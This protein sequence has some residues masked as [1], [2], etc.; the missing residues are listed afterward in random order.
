MVGLLYLSQEMSLK[1]QTSSDYFF[2]GRS[3]ASRIYGWGVW[4]GRARVVI[5][6]KHQ[7]YQTSYTAPCN[8]V[9]SHGAQF[10]VL[11]IFADHTRKS[12]CK[13]NALTIFTHR[14]AFNAWLSSHSGRPQYMHVTYAPD[15]PRLFC[16]REKSEDP[17]IEPHAG[18][19]MAQAYGISG[20]YLWLL[21]QDCIVWPSWWL[22]Q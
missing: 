2:G 16:F 17:Q 3:V 8:G 9:I 4:I 1:C 21:Y 22:R 20:V 11:R 10:G 12:K 6:D 5:T 19:K 7:R 18:I 13:T 15:E 14:P